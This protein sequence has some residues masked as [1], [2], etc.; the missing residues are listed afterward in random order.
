MTYTVWAISN[1]YGITNEEIILKTENADEA[2]KWARN[3]AN[4]N[5]RELHPERFSVEIRFNENYKEDGSYD[6]IDF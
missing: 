4:A 1:N 2:I 3:E 6:T 5:K